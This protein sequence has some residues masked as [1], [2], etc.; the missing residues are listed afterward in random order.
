M[1][2][3]GLQGP[4]ATFQR[5]MD[6]LI[7]GAHG[8]TAVYLDD[9]VIYST[10]WEDHL[11]HLQTVLLRLC[12]AGLTAKPSKC[13]YDIQQCIYL[14]FTVGGGIL[15]SEVGKLQAIQQLPVPKTKRDVRAFLG[16]TGYYHKFIP[17]Y[18]TIAVPL[19]DLTKKNAPKKVV[20]TEQYNQ[21]WQNLKG[22][23]TPDFSSQFILQTDASGCGVGAVPNK[24]IMEMTT[25][26]LIIVKNCYQEK[27][28]TL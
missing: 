27:S 9:L 14:G 12:K 3:F 8:F 24:T 5:M 26:L 11:Y 10:T 17:D 18:A 28:V 16:I 6:S 13:Q 2:P 1:M 22:L 7:H 15:K 23:R 4:H 21:A 20:W 19:A 25:L